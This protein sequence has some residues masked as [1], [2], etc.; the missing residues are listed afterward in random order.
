MKMICWLCGPVRALQVEQFSNRP[1]AR[2]VCFRGGGTKTFKGTLTLSRPDAFGMTQQSSEYFAP[3]F[4]LCSFGMDFALKFG[5]EDQ[6]NK[7]VFF[8][9]S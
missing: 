8:A 4:M 5:G 1:R 2:V 7:K 9:K 6:K 3:N